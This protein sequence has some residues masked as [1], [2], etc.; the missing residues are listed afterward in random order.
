MPTLDVTIVQADLCWHDAPA[1]RGQFDRMIDD[2]EG[3][4][5]LIVLPEM[6]TT[7][8]SMDAPALAE[9]MDGETVSWMIDR[10]RD[11]QAAICGSV[12]I[13]DGPDYLNRFICAKP[14]GSIITYDKR[15]LFRLA[16]EHNHYT[17]GN[18]IQV[19][20]LNGFRICPM[21]CYDLRFPAWSRNRNGNSYDLLLY[22]ANWPSR[23]HNAWATLLRARA[24]ENLSFLAG[25][26]RVGQDGNDL[27][28]IGGS[29]IIDYLGNDLADLGD[30]PGAATASLDLESLQKFRDRFAFHKDADSFDLEF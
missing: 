24:I 16:D 14:D 15:H 22:V 17:Q 13:S 20:E 19:F 30:K 21:I 2:I 12:I 5:D 9:S 26:N 28:Y 29:A 3:R 18:S 4:S 6:F 25:V 11:V 23:R 27:P 10:A 8:F 7:G 1:N